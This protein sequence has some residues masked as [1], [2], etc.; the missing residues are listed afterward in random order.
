[1]TPFTCRP[2]RAERAEGSPWGL[3][4]ILS[5]GPLGD[6]SASVGMTRWGDRNDNAENSQRHKLAM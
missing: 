2:E 1:M 6:S 3:S 4:C 5:R